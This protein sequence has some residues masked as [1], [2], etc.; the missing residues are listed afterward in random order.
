NIDGAL[1]DGLA[2]LKNAVPGGHTYAVLFPGRSDGLCL[3]AWITDSQTVIPGAVLNSNQGL[4]GQLGKEGVR[5]V[6]EGDIVA[7]STHLHYYSAD[8]GIRS[9]AGV[10]ILVKGV[11]RG[12]VIVDSLTPRAFDAATIELLDSLANLAGNLAYHAYM[13]WEHSSHK[14]Q[15][16]A[17]SNYQRKFLENMSVGNIATHAQTYMAECLEGDRFMVVERPARDSDAAVVANCI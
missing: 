15:L 12:A 1:F 16:A 7:E 9:L 3:R 10:P 8:E 17:L 14:E 2:L 4:V 5:R 6:L 13:A 11:R